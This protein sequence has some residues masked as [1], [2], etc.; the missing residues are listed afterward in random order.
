MNLVNLT[1]LLKRQL[2]EQSQLYLLGSLV[3]FGLL[4]TL[5]LIVHHWR[6]SFGGA[7]QNGVFLI[8]LF[9]SGGIF[10]ATMFQ[11]FSESAKGIWLLSIPA[12]AAEKIAAAILLSG[13]AFL[14]AYLGIYYLTDGL[15]TLLTYQKYGTTPLNLFRNGF[16]WLVC[17]YF[18]FNGI[19]LLGS[20]Y[21][22]K[23]SFVKT[24]LV[25]L[26][27]LVFLNYANNFLMGII[28]G[29]PNINSSTPLSGFQFEHQGEN[30]YV[31][32]PENIDS[33]SNI[34]ARA[35]LPLIFWSITWLRFREK[36][37]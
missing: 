25:L 21:F 11:E 28:S 7:V 2:K 32:L 31:N 37:V 27:V 34:F 9:G 4:A 35:V 33:I 36:E 26:L 15:Y 20:V 23:L 3:L 6:D 19:I 17:A 1:L 12:T 24:L 16:Y 18:L 13:F 5:F 10:T 30:I 8:G 22:T 29:I 14:V